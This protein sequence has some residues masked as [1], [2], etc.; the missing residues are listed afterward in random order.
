MHKG[1]KSKLA[2]VAPHIQFSTSRSEDHSFQWDGDGPD[3]KLR[4]YHPYDVTVSARV[5]AGGEIVEGNAYL[6]GSYYRRTQAT[7]DVHG[8]LPQMLD[9]ALDALHMKLENL[10][11]A[12]RAPAAVLVAEVSAA[13]DFLK[14]EMVARYEA[15]QQRRAK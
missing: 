1:L 9:E 8:Y 15:Q 10:P 13:R 6:G 14:Q 7:G 11:P 5:I 2:N 12:H 3:P 4:G